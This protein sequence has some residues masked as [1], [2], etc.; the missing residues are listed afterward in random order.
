MLVERF[1]DAT[2][3]LEIPRARSKLKKLVQNRERRSKAMATAH[4]RFDS[5]TNDTLSGLGL[6][7]HT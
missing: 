2:L 7:G 1:A 4:E 5:Y 3:R 6:I